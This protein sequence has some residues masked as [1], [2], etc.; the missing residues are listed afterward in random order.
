MNF[1]WIVWNTLQRAAV[2]KL[3]RI[4]GLCL[5]SRLILNSMNFKEFYLVQGN[6]QL[7]YVL[8]FFWKKGALTILSK[9][10][11][12]YL[13]YFSYFSPL[14]KSVTKGTKFDY[15]MVGEDPE[16][17]DEFLSMLE[18]RFLYL[19]ADA[20]STLRFLY[21]FY[22][23]YLYFNRNCIFFSPTTPMHVIFIVQTWPLW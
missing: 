7:Q 23:E 4:F 9:F 5:N 3:I 22:L 21:F 19:A 18:S 6:K 17:R 10:A 14:L 16:E 8:L 15:V 1:L 13:I 11:F 2:A 20:R 12:S